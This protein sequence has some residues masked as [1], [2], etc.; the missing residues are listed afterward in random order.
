MIMVR[1]LRRMVFVF[2]LGL[3]F[4]G[5]PAAA[6]PITWSLTGTV[7]SSSVS[8][9]SVGDPASMLLTFDSSAI[10]VEPSPSCGLYVG[11]ILSATANFGS[12]AFTAGPG[13]GIE[14][15][16]GSGA[17]AACGITPGNVSA[18]TYRAFSTVSL[19]AFFENGLVPSDAL[20]LAPPPLA[21][22]DSG[23]RVILPSGGTAIAEIQAARVIPEPGTLVLIGLGLA[24]STMR[25]AASRSD[26]RSRGARPPAARQSSC[27]F[28]SILP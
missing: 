20:L 7:S 13:G 19:I 10:D 22:F 15:S 28:R 25:R 14:V 11:A 2:G 1:D 9:I 12:Q 21:L 4:I 24:G 27:G 5:A 8:G 16:D 3:V 26:R 23:L 6:S 18:Y 17:V